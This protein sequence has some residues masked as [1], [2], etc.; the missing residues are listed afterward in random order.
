MSKLQNTKST[1]AKLL[2]SENITVVHQSMPTAA[3]DLTTRTLYCPIWQ[4]MDGDLYDLLMGHEVGHA[5]FTP[6]E[7][8]HNNI[9]PSAGISKSILNVIE[10]ARIEKLMKR[11]YQG[12]VRSFSV[13]YA[14]LNSRDF[15]GTKKLNDFSALNF[16][17]RINLQFKIG[18]YCIIPFSSEEN[19]IV[20][21]I[22]DAET[23]EEVVEL[24]KI[25]TEMVKEDQSAIKS[26]KD[27]EQEIKEQFWQQ[28]TDEGDDDEEEDEGEAE[29][30]DSIESEEEGSA[31]SEEEGAEVNEEE[32][33]D[34]SSSVSD[35]EAEEDDVEEESETESHAADDKGG[36]ASES[37]D[38]TD[39][40]VESITDNIFREHEK[41]LTNNDTVVFSYNLP[42]VNLEHTI[43]KIDTL[44]SNFSGFWKCIDWNGAS[45]RSTN[46]RET[47]RTMFKKTNDAF[48]MLMVKQ[49]IMK[50]NASQYARTQTARS[51]ELDMSKIH[52]YK[53]TNDIFS[54]INVVP[55]GQSHGM[56]LFLDMSS[57][58]DSI[59]PETVEQLLILASFCKRVNIPFDIYGFSDWSGHPNQYVKD[60]AAFKMDRFQLNHLLSSSFKGT[61]YQN[62]FDMLLA[63]AY[64]RK[65]YV[66]GV[67]VSDYGFALGGTPLLGA[68]LASRTIIDTFKAKHRL[69]VV[70]C[71][72]LTDGEAGDNTTS[73]MGANG[74][75]AVVR[76]VDP[77]TKQTLVINGHIGNFQHHI[78][79][80]VSKL[81]GCK[82]IGLY[83]GKPIMMKSK[84]GTLSLSHTVEQVAE[85]KKSLQTMKFFSVATNGFDK[86]F[87]IQQ[88]SG[89]VRDDSYSLTTS[90]TV[91][92]RELRKMASEFSKAQVSKKASRMYV[93]KFM[94]EIA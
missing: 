44:L 20:Q 57:S 51:G 62:A 6:E 25:V 63:V 16:A 37:S 47:N 77:I 35:D 10:D 84:L 29:E 59:F 34:A 56:V 94:E 93:T 30:F 33:D 32:G 49:F 18:A 39:G 73:V 64:R 17:D 4:S 40:E 90:D 72:Q 70:T 46:F 1:L 2:A 75:A 19:A 52:K 5:L 61:V 50:R 21:R 60:E 38:D 92:K 76:I 9:S 26:K 69:D 11:R 27:L 87:F 67:K 24:A 22:A 66:A 12:L 45:A 31:E 13:A 23:W 80:F 58:M 65:N 3:F 55:R 78:T 82:T 85:M 42:V 83:V 8:W 7:G 89:N 54:K 81:T 48:I 91:G 74:K 79:G 28:W 41:S 53:F 86:Y 15:F 68:T 43:V 88:D 36:K 71:I 14:Q